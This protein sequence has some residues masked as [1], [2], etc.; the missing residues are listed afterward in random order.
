MQKNLKKNVQ[1]KKSTKWKGLKTIF[2]PSNSYQ[3]LD[4]VEE[5]VKVTTTQTIVEET[6]GSPNEET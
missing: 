2:S 5:K 6:N 4:H 1:V 3:V